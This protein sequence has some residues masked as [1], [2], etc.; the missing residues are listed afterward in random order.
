VKA[1][2]L[3]V[4]LN[5]VQ[6]GDV[7]LDRRGQLVFSYREEW[8]AFDGGIPLS[9]SMPLA[10]PV[11]GHDQIEPFLLGL[12]PDGELLDRWAKRFQVSPRNPFA[13]LAHTGEDCPG[14]V[15]FVRPDRLPELQRE[16]GLHA[17]WLT[18]HDVA[19]RLR[20]L[21]KDPAA[22]RLEHDDGQFSL[23]GAQAKTALILHDGRWGV[24]SGRTPTTHILKPPIQDF[25]G[26]AEN[27]HLCLALLAEL[28]LRAATSEVRRFEDVVV[29]VVE[30]FDRFPTAAL[31]SS[32]A[33]E[34]AAAAAAAASATSPEE[35]AQA[36]A[37][38][39]TAAARASAMGE[40]A[41]SQPILRLHQEDVCQALSRPPRLKYQSD[42]GPGPVEIVG[43]LRSHS[44][45]AEEDV[46][47]F[48]DALIFNWLIAGTDAH[49]K[50]YGL[51]QDR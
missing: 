27:E 11:H 42:G 21:Q 41:R 38:T 24:P 12:L 23:A 16:Q 48:V 25:D 3:V 17:D 9:L 30:R 13:L 31:A 5:G 45:S 22:A 20:L 49:G 26:H 37:R 46:E 19:Q 34:A 10:S 6:I 33:A 8:R 15:Q 36:A 28:G 51:L 14:A 39:A 4:L 47:T 7:D 29:I 35:A 44:T 40:M 18:E 50:N 43:L 1:D 2:R 32:A